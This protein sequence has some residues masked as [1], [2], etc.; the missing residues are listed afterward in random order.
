MPAE[1][2]SAGLHFDGSP[3]PSAVRNQEDIAA[4]LHELKK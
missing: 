4:T 3:W 1:K 2:G